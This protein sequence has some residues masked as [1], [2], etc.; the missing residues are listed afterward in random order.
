MTKIANQGTS[1][2]SEK[3]SESSLEHYTMFPFD[4]AQERP[5]GLPSAFEEAAQRGKNLTIYTADSQDF[6][7][8]GAQ[9]KGAD[10][11][12][13]DPSDRFKLW[14]GTGIWQWVNPDAHTETAASPEAL[15]AMYPQEVVEQMRLASQS[16]PGSLEFMHACVE[17]LRPSLK[18]EAVFGQRFERLMAGVPPQSVFNF[19]DF[20]AK[21]LM[22]SHATRL[23]EKGVHLTHHWHTNIALSLPDS[24]WG[25]DML[26]ATAL[27]DEVFVHT[28]V[29]KHRLETLLES[30]Q[31]ENTPTVRR[32]DIPIDTGLI[33][34]SLQS[35]HRDNYQTSIPNFHTLPE[36]T[37]SVVQ[38]IFRTQ[39]EVSTVKHRFM[40]LDRIDPVKGNDVVLSALDAHFKEELKSGKTLE[41]LQADYRVFLIGAIGVHASDES[42]LW[43]RYVEHV[44]DQLTDL[45]TRYPGIFWSCSALSGAQRIAVPALMRGC[46][47]ISGTAQDGFGLAVSESAIINENEKAAVIAGSNSGFSMQMIDEGLGDAFLHPVSGSVDSFKDALKQ[48]TFRS[49]DHVVHRRA[50]LVNKLRSRND[51]IIVDPSK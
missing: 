16:Q 39:P 11:E 10:P 5:G 7:W 34:R 43:G 37:Q 36:Q 44:T 20:F 49:S 46:H 17:Q 47:S 19:H 15:R 31:L 40:S 51:S 29:Y 13:R 3:P 33:A 14:F 6:P 18:N 32:F 9:V 26:R 35:I 50:E 8:K 23:R 12:T 4:L 42:N 28:D 25:R 1:T 38:E 22:E 2:E 30:L 24:K 45:Q 41:D 27:M 48:A 21:P